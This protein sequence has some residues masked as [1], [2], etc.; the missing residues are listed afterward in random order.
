MNQ[1]S[2]PSDADVNFHGLQGFATAVITSGVIL[3]QS[4][5]F[6]SENPTA[7]WDVILRLPCKQASRHTNREHREEK[8][9]WIRDC[10][11]SAGALAQGLCILV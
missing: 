3:I 4:N 6:S 11:E 2:V 5:S 9:S 10:L 8:Q 7:F 1:L